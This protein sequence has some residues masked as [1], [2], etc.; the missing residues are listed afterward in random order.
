[1]RLMPNLAWFR[2]HFPELPILPGV[3]R[4]LLVER[5]LH[6]FASDDAALAERLS[7][8]VS[9]VKNLKFKAITK[10]GMRMRLRLA[11][12]K[13]APGEALRVKFEWVR[14]LGTGRQGEDHQ[15]T[16]THEAPHSLG[17][18]EFAPS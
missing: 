6:E 3:A 8:G 5:A 2:G 12:A 16:D 13:P 17:I 1:M 14:P 18:L 10:P 9:T 4:L 11:F 15:A 7:Q